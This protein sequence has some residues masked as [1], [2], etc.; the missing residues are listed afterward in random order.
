[1]AKTHT[2]VLDKIHAKLRSAFRA[3]DDAADT[4]HAQ[5]G[6]ADKRGQQLDDLA[7]DVHGI[8][9]QYACIL[10]DRKDGRTPARRQQDELD[11]LIHRQGAV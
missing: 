2:E 5:W 7:R 9:T 11:D 1:M 3:I 10:A 4:A 6:L 8:E